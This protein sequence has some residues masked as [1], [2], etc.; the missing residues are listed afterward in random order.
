[1]SG[2]ASLWYVRKVRAV[3]GPGPR[4]GFGEAGQRDRGF[5]IFS[6]SLSSLASTLPSKGTTPFALR[7][8]TGW[9]DSGEHGVYY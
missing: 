4:R 2:A 6:A 1:M 8:R 7:K 9:K 5:V 3:V